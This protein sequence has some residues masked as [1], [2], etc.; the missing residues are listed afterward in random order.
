MLPV[1]ELSQGSAQTYTHLGV[2]AGEGGG[3]E[4]VFLYSKALMRQNAPM[5]ALE[6]LFP[7]TI[8]GGHSRSTL[9]LLMWP[10]WG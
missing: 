9:R 6:V 7:I 1:P 2:Q 10:P 8:N 3:A 5:P 4:G